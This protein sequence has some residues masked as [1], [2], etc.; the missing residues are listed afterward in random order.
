MIVGLVMDFLDMLEEKVR[1][2]EEK[3]RDMRR[4]IEEEK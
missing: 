2:E 1:Y 3:Y 4:K